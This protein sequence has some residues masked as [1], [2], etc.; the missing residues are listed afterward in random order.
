MNFNAVIL[1]YFDQTACIPFGRYAVTIVYSKSLSTL[2]RFI[3]LS[4]GR[5]K[6]GNMDGIN[7]VFAR[8]SLFLVLFSTDGQ[9]GPD[10]RVVDREACSPLVDDACTPIDIDM[11]LS[12]MRSIKTSS[13]T[14]SSALNS[15]DIHDR[16]W[17]SLGSRS[18]LE[19]A[20]G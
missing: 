9:D 2:S 10:L 8:S 19:T 7:F 1:S 12:V 11:T 16:G 15:S 13:K 3:V 4:R 17:K 5:M 18:N 14:H 20:I 6:L